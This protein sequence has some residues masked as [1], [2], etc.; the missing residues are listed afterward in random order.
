MIQ[1][2]LVALDG[3]Q[4]A[5]SVFPFVTTIARATRSRL[6]LIAAVDA[7]EG[8]PEGGH[9]D[10]NRSAEAYL[11]SIRERLATAIERPIEARVVNAPPAQAILDAADDTDADLIAMTMHRRTGLK[12]WLLGGTATKVVH[13]SR[14]PVLVVRPKDRQ[15]ALEPTTGPSGQAPA[16]Q[17]ILVPLDA[18]ELSRSALPFAEDLAKA[19]G[20]SLVVM[21]AVVPPAIAYPGAEPVAIPQS[22]ITDIEASAYAFARGIAGE[23]TARGLKAKPVVLTGP[24]AEAIVEAAEAEDA[25]LIIMS[26]HGRSGV[27]RLLLGSTAE[28]VVRH[29]PIPVT[30]VPPPR[31]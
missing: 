3:S 31:E 30:L 25:D 22:V 18:S 28:A 2:I 5:E 14:R 7:R 17:T 21:H 19:L 9:D 4:A 26:T 15:G 13:A 6:D 24:A 10:D 16:L 12:D 27:Q 20:S 1:T 8:W 29:S 23:L 11:D